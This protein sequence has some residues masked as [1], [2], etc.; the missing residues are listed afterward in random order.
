MK[1]LS[2]LLILFIT[3]IFVDQGIAH[4]DPNRKIYDAMD[5]R[6]SND[7]GY[8]VKVDGNLVCKKK[9][10]DPPVY[11]CT[12]NQP[13]GY[14]D[15]AK[16]AFDTLMKAD[17]SEPESISRRGEPVRTKTVGSIVCIGKTSLGDTIYKCE[18]IQ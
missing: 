14:D 17:S 7:G 13:E 16:K 8:E 12:Y 2:L 1:K 5:V 9:T 4:A 15:H 18:D 11:D 10:D 6:A 3:V